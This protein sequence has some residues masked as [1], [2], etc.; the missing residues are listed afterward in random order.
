MLMSRHEKPP[1]PAASQLLRDAQA[2]QPN[3]NKFNGWGL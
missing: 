1:R 3:N 2:R